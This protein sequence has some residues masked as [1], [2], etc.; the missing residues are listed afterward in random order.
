M[1]LAF[2]EL[3]TDLQMLLF[4]DNSWAKKTPITTAEIKQIEDVW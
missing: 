3:T 4:V 2:A 1:P